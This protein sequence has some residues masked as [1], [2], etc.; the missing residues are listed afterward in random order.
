MKEI[1][2]AQEKQIYA[3]SQSTGL[4]KGEYL[5][6][7]SQLNIGATVTNT[8]ATVG[9]ASGVI[10]TAK[11]RISITLVN[12]SDTTIYLAKGSTAVL[13]SGIRLNA[14]GGSV[15]ICDWRGAISAISSGASKNLTICEVV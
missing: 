13:N 7:E 2:N 5:S 10:S 6:A 12:D 11:D 15:I 4:T 3:F 1:V 9:V 14:S 8:Y